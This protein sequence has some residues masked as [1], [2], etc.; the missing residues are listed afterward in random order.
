[1]TNKKLDDFHITLLRSNNLA[2][3]WQPELHVVFILRGT[4]KFLYKTVYTV[5]EGDIFT[6][7][8]LEGQNLSLGEN[9]I[10]LSLS[11]SF[12]FIASV[13]PDILQYHMNCYSFLYGE[14]QQESFDILRCDLAKAFQTQYK[15]ESRYEIYLKNKVVV[16]LEDMMRYFLDERQPASSRG[17]WEKLQAAITYIQQHYQENITLEDLAGQTYLSSTYLSRL[18][19]KQLG[20][21]FTEYLA[22][23]RL[24]HAIDLM[25]GQD[26][27]T[28]IVY[29]TGFPNSNA[30]INA[31]KKEWDITPGEYRKTLLNE[32]KE[33]PEQKEELVD[34]EDVFYPLMKYLKEPEEADSPAESVDEII[35]DTKGK[36]QKLTQHWKRVMNAGYARDLLDGSWQSEMRYLQ[37]KIGFEYIRIKGVLDD[38]MCILREDMNGCPVLNYAYIDEVLD[39]ILSMNG[40]PM[41]EFS[42]MPRVLAGNVTVVSMRFSVV[43]Y[44]TNIEQWAELIRK[45]MEHFAQR[46]GISQVKRWLFTPCF[47]PDYIDFGIFSQ[48]E[49]E[50]LYMAGYHAVKSVCRD[51]LVCGPG[52]VEYQKHLR[53]FIQMC[54]R[55]H[56]LPEILTFRSYASVDAGTEENGLNLIEN[57]QSFS[58]AVSRDEDFVRYA[59]QKIREIQRREG[60]EQLALVMDEWNS[61]IWQRD[62]CNDT[63]FKSAY[64]FKNILENNHLLNG[65]GYFALSDRLAEVPPAGDLFH[66]GFG[67]YTK[68]GIPKSACRAMELLGQMGGMLLKQGNGYFITQNEEDIQI[69]LYNY[70]HFDL[71]YR[72]RHVANMSRTNRYQV[73][74]Q[75]EPRA[76][77]IQLLH[78]SPGRYRIQRYGITRNGGG[79]YEAWV[80]MGA[81]ASVDY[82]ELELLRD[83]SHPLYRTEKIDIASEEDSLLVR[84]S[85]E[86]HDVW[87][88]KIKKQ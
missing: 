24:A 41:L 88:I 2:E 54:K 86:P 11:I 71:L 21:P 56:C 65:M 16:I 68:N 37:E 48:E 76:F 9:A 52:C 32:K 36:K 31:F 87:L 84:E 81:P 29:K 35:V 67:L 7:N 8:G 14:N 49:Y 5:H 38:D 83:I 72:Y 55:N 62:L 34:T 79:S 1:M 57:N 42:N 12:D 75:K 17:N 13:C 44:P 60:V 19:T 70:S 40:R 59:V 47:P 3:S 39:L 18:F 27:L 50:K 82:E 61:N 45:M 58:Y 51:F 74:V 33:L 23:V 20:L 25:H 15:S 63:C 22:Q 78:L 66:G 69:F 30:M 64:L 46:Y 26:T 53:L 28:E 73:F 4:G 80:R 10:A 85:L 6:I 77:C 43:S